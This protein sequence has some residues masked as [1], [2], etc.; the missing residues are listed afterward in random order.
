[1][2]QRLDDP[3]FDLRV[4]F[5]RALP[6]GLQQLNRDYPSCDLL[7]EA[8]GEEEQILRD[9]LYRFDPAPS[10]AQGHYPQDYLRSFQA[11]ID[12]LEAHIFQTVSSG[13]EF[14]RSDDVSSRCP[15][16]TACDLPTRKDHPLVC[17]ETPWLSYQQAM[18]T[19]SGC[20]Y[21]TAVAATLGI[22]R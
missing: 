4:A 15:F 1:M 21:Y 14:R 11:Q 13:A 10:D 22:V 8:T 2:P 20:W 12:Y 5:P 19:A 3:L 6:E 16:F 18:T 7:Q 9:Q 17:R